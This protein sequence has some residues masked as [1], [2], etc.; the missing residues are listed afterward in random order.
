[1]CRVGFP[2]TGENLKAE[3]SDSRGF[4]FE[5]VRPVPMFVNEALVV[6]GD[7]PGQPEGLPGPSLCRTYVPEF[8]DAAES[9]RP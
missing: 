2:F 9:F 3:W 1:M 4:E 6:G 7:P 5:N 8:L